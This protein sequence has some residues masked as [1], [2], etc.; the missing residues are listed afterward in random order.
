MNPITILLGL[1]AL[2]IL[3]WAAWFVIEFVRYLVS[4]EY[5]ADKRLRD[6]CR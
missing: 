3:G 2:L 4:G 6:I 1:P 5:E